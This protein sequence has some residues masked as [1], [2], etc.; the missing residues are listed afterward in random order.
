MKKIITISSIIL[1][2]N[3]PNLANAQGEPFIGEI[4]MFAGN[5][6]PRGWAMCD[7]Q[8]LAVSQNDALFSILGT[9]YG[10]DG[11]TTFALP[12]LRSRVPIHAGTGPGFSTRR[13][14]SKSGSETNILSVNNLPS[15]SH[16]VNAVIED[17]NQSL[18]TGN[19]PAGTKLLDKEYSDATGNTTM[20]ASMLNNTGNNQAVNNMQPYLTIHYIIATIG[21]FPSRN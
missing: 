3:L 4:V 16:T 11:R 15:H 19:L 18:P 20:S 8:L 17:G 13:L 10:G 2:L 7:G 9:T 1:F 21:V 14:G 12:D 5:F 6:A